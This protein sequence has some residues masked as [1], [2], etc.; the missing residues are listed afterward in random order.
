MLRGADASGAIHNVSVEL[1]GTSVALSDAAEVR[2]V[3]ALYAADHNDYVSLN[4]CYNMETSPIEKADTDNIDMDATAY[5]DMEDD[6][7]L[8][9]LEDNF[10]QNEDLTVHTFGPSNSRDIEW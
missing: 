1:H 9:K 3:A 4:L 10:E 6:M 8:W 2:V 7:E 5:Y